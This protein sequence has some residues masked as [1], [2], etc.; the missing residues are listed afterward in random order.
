MAVGVGVWGYVT[1][2]LET[3]SIQHFPYYDIPDRWAMYVYGSI[4]YGLYFLVSYPMFY[5]LDERGNRWS[6]W[7]TVVDA[8]ACSMLI[9]TLLDAWRLCIGK[10]TD[11]PPAHPIH[12]AVPFIY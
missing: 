8:M 10:V 2:F 9:T 3:W 11:K 4:F 6:L 7:R 12:P 1:A 5:A